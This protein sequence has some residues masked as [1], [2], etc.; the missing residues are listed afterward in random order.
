MRCAPACPQALTR[1]DFPHRSQAPHTNLTQSIY[2]LVP[3]SSIRSLS[4]HHAAWGIL[5]RAQT[6]ESGSHSFPHIRIH[7]ASHSYFIFRH[8]FTEKLKAGQCL[9]LLSNSIFCGSN[10]FSP[11]HW[12]YG[13]ETSPDC[14]VRHTILR[15]QL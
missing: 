15:L 10:F 2:R 7:T 6:A 5:Y 9:F 1:S 12:Y 11:D 14:W 3:C 13:I 4:Q 8:L